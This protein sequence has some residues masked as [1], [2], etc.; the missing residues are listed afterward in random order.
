[1][2]KL[3]AVLLAV[4]LLASM[5]PAA[6][7]DDTIYTEGTLHYTIDNDSVTII[8]CFGRDA[9]VWV[10][11]MIAGYP[12]NTIASGAFAENEAVQTLYLPDTIAVI[13]EGAIGDW[14]HVVY[15]ANTDHPQDTPTDLIL[16]LMPTVPPL[17]EETPAVQPTEEPAPQNGTGTQSGSGSVDLEEGTQ[18][19][20][21]GQTGTQISEREIDLTEKET[22]APQTPAPASPSPEVSAESEPGKAEPETGTE[23]PAPTAAVPETPE[24][25][26]G[27]LGPVLGVGGV[28]VLALGAVLLLR[29]KKAGAERGIDE[30]PRSEDQG[31]NTP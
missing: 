3:L 18:T 30:G 19:G 5:A 20:R 8:N 26:D 4:L 29:R 14:I 17:P 7:A 25:S 12:V 1:M 28:A 11:A 13:E 15:N 9:E 6:F 22:P 21:Q 27:A 16:G 10:P 24:K 2:K 23:A 31:Q